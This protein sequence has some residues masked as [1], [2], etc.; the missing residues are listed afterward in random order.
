[1]GIEYPIRLRTIEA[2]IRLRHG[3]DRD[4]SADEIQVL[5]E[6]AG[7]IVDDIANQWPVDTSTSR[8]AFSYTIELDGV[9]FVI[10][11]DAD[12]AQYVHRAGTPAEPALFETLIPEVVDAN[13]EAMFA[14][15]R[16]AV[17]T[18]EAQIAMVRPG[19]KRQR[20]ILDILSGAA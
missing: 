16:R 6:W 9:G 7:V 5:Q 2:Y 11:N 15:M 17:D 12:Y 1:M 13:I 8:D 19:K 14:A 18:T 10:L 20:G 4:M 3:S